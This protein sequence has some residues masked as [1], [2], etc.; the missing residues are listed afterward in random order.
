MVYQIIN[1]RAST[2]CLSVFTD[3]Y[4]VDKGDNVI[5]EELAIACVGSGKGE[6]RSI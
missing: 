2:K 6:W 3:I 1:N 5:V 4:M